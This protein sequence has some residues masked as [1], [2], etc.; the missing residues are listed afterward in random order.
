MPAGL[1]SPAALYLAAAGVGTIGIIDFDAVDASNLQRQILHGTPD[2]GRSKLQ[3]ARDR[4]SALNPEV[5]IETHEAALTS[6][7]ALA[8]FRDYDVILDGTDNFATRY[9]VN[10][11]CVLLGKPNAYGSIFR[12]EGQASVFATKDGPCYRC[13]YPEPPPPG[14]VPSCAEG[15]VLGVLPG[16]IG[17]IQAT[18]S[19]KL[20]LGGGSTLDR[21][22]AAVRRLEHALPRAEAAARSRLPGLRRSSDRPRADRLRP[23][24]RHHAA[25][26]RCRGQRRPAGGSRSQ[27]RGAEGASRRP[28]RP[29]YLLDVREPHEF[30]ICRIP[31]STLIPLGQLPARV[32][33]A[34]AGR[35]APEIIVHCS[36]GVRSAKAVRQLQERGIASRNLKGGILA[37]ID[38]IDPTLPKILNASASVIPHMRW[39]LLWG[40]SI[41][42]VL[43]PFFLFE[44]QFNA[45]AEQITR[46]GMSRSVAAGGIFALLALDVFLPVPSSIVATGAGV[47]L[48]LAEGTAVVWGG[49]MAGCL[50][51]IRNRRAR[52]GNGALDRR[53][54]ITWCGPSP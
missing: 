44:A 22:P 50:I 24:L 47:I 39:A 28:A 33:R 32:D 20:L 8:L 3:S 25:R 36:S 5:R 40:C 42:L 7:N 35:G 38:R 21:P 9:L 30:Q 26:G 43:L 12:F 51:R 41:G 2:V 18:E 10:D 23:V 46:S 19:I 16:V 14:L 49:M 37:W 29:L 31:G 6:K 54:R 45:L 48:G 53:L 17:T 4:L 15:G 11:A 34:A 13:L 27:R 52:G 1:G